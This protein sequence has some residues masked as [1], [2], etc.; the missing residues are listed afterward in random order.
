M[1]LR[2]LTNVCQHCMNWF[3]AEN[4]PRDFYAEKKASKSKCWRPEGIPESFL[5]L[6]SDITTYS[7]AEDNAKTS[8]KS[9]RIGS[10]L[11]WEKDLDFNSWQTAFKDE[12][13]LWC[14]LVV[15]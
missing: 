10:A 6:V 15:L 13:R 8:L 2:I 7:L 4:E 3:N 12:L 14:R 11:M 5:D 1:D 9:E